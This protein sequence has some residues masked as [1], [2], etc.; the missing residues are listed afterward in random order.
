MHGE[1]PRR[2]CASWISSLCGFVQAPA[3]FSSV[4]QHAVISASCY[5]HLRFVLCFVWETKFHAHTTRQV[6]IKL[7]E[8]R[9]EFL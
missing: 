7:Y 3:I 1:D 8:V 9:E 5:E 2:Q 6:N 4:G